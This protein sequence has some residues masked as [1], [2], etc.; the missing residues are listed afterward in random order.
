MELRV[1][2]LFPVYVSNVHMDR[3]NKCLVSDSVCVAGVK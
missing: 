1:G 2:A 3:G